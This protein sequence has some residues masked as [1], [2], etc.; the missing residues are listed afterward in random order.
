VEPVD[1][2][3]F[4]IILGGASATITLVGAA[5]GVA[6]AATQAAGCRRTC[7]RHAT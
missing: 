7:A 3:T 2:R 1:R 4:L 6:C 5:I